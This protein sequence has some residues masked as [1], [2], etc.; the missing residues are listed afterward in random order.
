MT[1]SE[2]LGRLRRRSQE[3]L[4]GDV[5]RPTYK[6]PTL[7]SV[8]ILQ[9]GVSINNALQGEIISV[10]QG[11]VRF[12]V[13]RGLVEEVPKMKKQG[14]LRWIYEKNENSQG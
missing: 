8:R 4:D 14:L 13:A 7:F 11:Q 9:K 3:I 10:P 12:L 5:R 6:N 2:A 1:K